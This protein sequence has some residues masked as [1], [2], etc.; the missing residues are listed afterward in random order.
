MSMNRR[1]LTWLSAVLVFGI[2]L[3]VVSAWP[4]W[5][6]SYELA[7]EAQRQEENADYLRNSNPED[8]V[9]VERLADQVLASEGEDTEVS[10][11]KTNESGDDSRSASNHVPDADWLELPRLG[12]DVA[13]YLTGPPKNIK[14][15]KLLRHKELNPGDVYISDLRRT[16]CARLINDLLV[17]IERVMVVET[18]SASKEFRDLIE[19]GRAKKRRVS[20][21]MNSLSERER[22]RVISLKNRLAANARKLAEKAGIEKKHNLNVVVPGLFFKESSPYAYR[23]ENG[24]IYQATLRELPATYKAAELRVFLTMELVSKTLY[25]FA[26]NTQLPVATQEKILL[27]AHSILEDIIR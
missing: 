21:V 14:T 9:R 8:S 15:K 22:R 6:R 25:W 12:F 24:S 20:E 13:R 2:A 17:R 19:S 7:E 10:V 23:S 5:A 4:R 1:V 27:R 3:Y 26:K 18:N 16:E 11:A